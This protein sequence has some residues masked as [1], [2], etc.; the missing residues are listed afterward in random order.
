RL[1][2]RDENTRK[3]D[4]VPNRPELGLGAAFQQIYGD[5]GIVGSPEISAREGVHQRRLARVGHSDET[6]V[7]FSNFGGNFGRV[8]VAAHWT[9]IQAASRLRNANNAPRTCIT[10]GSPN[11]AACVTGT[12]SPGV[13][14]KSRSRSQSS[15]GPSS[16][17]IRNQRLRG[18]ADSCLRIGLPA[19]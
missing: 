12:S 17:S 1:G 18:T 11:G 9:Q 2:N 5:P 19:K 15:C 3:I 13:N 8:R 10:M 6:N 14:P 4:Q 16:R 7:L